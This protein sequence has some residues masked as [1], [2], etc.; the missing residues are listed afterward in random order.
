MTW[1]ARKLQAP[2]LHPRRDSL[3]GLET[4]HR[5]LVFIHPV[6]QLSDRELPRFGERG[7][8]PTQRLSEEQQQFRPLS[9][10]QLLGCAFDLNQRLHQVNLSLC[11]GVDNSGSGL[12]ARLVPAIVDLDFD[13]D[14]VAEPMIVDRGIVR[15]S[16]G[17]D[18]TREAVRGESLRSARRR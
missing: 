3:A 1:P 18:K 16:S 5:L 17:K 11:P 7:S 15:P 9:R 12:R 13:G 10:R 2:R 4:M 14:P 8:L 6:L